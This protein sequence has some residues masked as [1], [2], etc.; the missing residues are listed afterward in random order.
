MKKI[1]LNI[2]ALSF[3]L[4]SAQDRPIGINL[5]EAKD[6][7]PQFLFKDAF[8]QSREWVVQPVNNEEE[9]WDKA[10]IKYSFKK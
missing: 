10:H 4:I 9:I 3:L 6:W 7:W 8:K 2:F 5:T 1:T